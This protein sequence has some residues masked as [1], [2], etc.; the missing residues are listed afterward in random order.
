M[1]YRS[2]V[3]AIFY[4]VCGAGGTA[5]LLKANALLDLW[6]AAM[7]DTQPFKADWGNCFSKVEN[8]YVFECADVKWYD[9]YPAIT[10]FNAMVEKFCTDFIDNEKLDDGSGLHQMFCYEFAR[11]G[12]E[13]EDIE[14][15]IRGGAEYRLQVDRSV[16]VE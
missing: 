10:G 4:V 14:I 13:L 11:I 16:R 9:T 7:Q 1:G 8:G 2:D 15:D 6:Y 12:E 3:T 5:P